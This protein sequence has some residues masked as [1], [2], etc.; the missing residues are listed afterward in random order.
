MNLAGTS[1]VGWTRGTGRAVSSRGR[2]P[3]TGT[4][5]DPAFLAATPAELDR[6]AALAASAFPLF[7]AWEPARRAALLRG[8]ADRLEALGDALGERVTAETGLPAARVVS[9]RGRTCAQLRMFAELID[10]GSWV[11][12]RIERA[13]PDRRPVPKPDLRSM[14][15]P[16]GPVAVF[17]AGNFP[18]AYSVAGG[19]TASALAAGCPV[20]VMAHPG[21]PGTAELVA[22]AV[23]AAAQA[24][25]APEGVFSLLHGEGWS[26]GQALVRHPAVRAAGFTGSRAGGRA[27]MDL[28]A[29]RPDPIPF[30]AEMSSVNP[31]FLLPGAVAVRGPALAEGLHQSVT[32]GAGQ[33]CTK[34]GLVFL[35]DQAESARWVSDLA[36]RLGGT[37]PAPLLNPGIAANYAQRRRALGELNGVAGVAVGGGAPDG[38]ACA[39]TPAL[40]RTTAAAFLAEPAMQAEVFGPCTLLV[41]CDDEAQMRECAAS[42][43]GQL[44]ATVHAEPEELGDWLD[45][46]R[47][48]AGRLIVNGFP[49]GVEVCHAMVHGGPFPATSDGRT[50]SVGPQ[51]ITR[52]TRAVCYQNCPGSA[53][54]PELRDD[55]PRGIWRMEDGTRKG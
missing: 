3:V 18:L 29:A 40:F 7:S 4:E 54:P 50:T 16:L 30:Y 13:Q 20:I 27:L 24:A 38:I 15:V 39:G 26:T 21:H 53:L 31:V 19:D 25:G 47:P 49:T 28:A 5:L 6:A 35:C 23:V 45:W 14:Q 1:W 8:V 41:L 42:L 52:W 36:R 12:A 34:P 22:G 33:F 9:E 32:Q 2:D 17:C 46:L 55:N 44:T 37:A 48:K 10:E 11:D 43:E 51:A